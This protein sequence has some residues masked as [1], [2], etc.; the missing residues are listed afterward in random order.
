MNWTIDVQPEV[1]V[2]LDALLT[3]LTDSYVSF[4]ETRR[5]AR[6]QAGI[7]V[8]AVGRIFGSLGKNPYR[9]TIANLD[10]VELRHL[11][12]DRVIVWFRL[13][14]AAHVIHIIGVFFG[15][16]DHLGRMVSRLTERD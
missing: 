10:G 16:Q 4:G 2:D 5:E 11:T 6:Q 14:E 8:M 3:Y 15:G 12:K 9:G 1:E 7:R 13:D